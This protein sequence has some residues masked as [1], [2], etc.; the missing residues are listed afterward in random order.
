MAVDV[1]VVD[2]R[3]DL[4]RFIGLPWLLYQEDARW[5]PPLRSELRAQLNTRKNPYFE[6]AEAKYFLAKRN[7]QVVGR[8]SAQV[9]QLV[10]THLGQGIGQFGFFECENAQ[11]TADQLFRAAEEWLHQQGMQQMLGPFSHS[12]NDEVGLLVDGF[13]RTPSILMGHHRPYYEQLMLNGGFG[14]EMDVFAYHLDISQPYTKRIQR[15]VDW[16]E[17]RSDIR[18]RPINQEKYSD[19]LRLALQLFQEAWSGNWGYI[20]PTEAEVEHL[21]QTMMRILHRGSVMFAELEGK[22]VGFIVALPNINEIIGDL[23]GKL[24][25][26]GWLRLLWR[27]RFA[28]FASVRVP[29]LGIG[30]EYQKS[31]LGAAIALLLIDRCRDDLLPQGVTHCEM[32]WILKTNEPMR[33]ILDASGSTL[34]KTYRIYAKSIGK[35]DGQQSSGGARGYGARGLRPKKCRAAHLDHFGQRPFS[36]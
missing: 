19:E 11:D 15:I 3:A 26:T 8:I 34:D 24:F 29:L 7:G 35:V 28:K 23:D 5:V 25:P 17:R 36:S 18:I 4:E 14:E 12:I 30:K 21:L 13:D 31:R 27:L 2:T 32:S 33:A 9:C 1:G 10:Q 16:A 6:H 22:P 20:P